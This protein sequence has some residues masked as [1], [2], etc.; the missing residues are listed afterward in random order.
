MH[1]Q[2]T[3]FSGERGLAIGGGLGCLMIVV[4]Y[5]L[6]GGILPEIMHDLQVGEATYSFGADRGSSRRIRDS[7]TGLP[8]LPHLES[9]GSHGLPGAWR[10][11]YYDMKTAVGGGE[12]LVHFGGLMAQH[13]A[14]HFPP[15]GGVKA[16]PKC[17]DGLALTPLDRAGT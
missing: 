1:R 11:R 5:I 2:G 7:D 9:A 16:A 14:K 6:L 3:P 15:A 13:R 10:N 12:K 4:A 8:I 17:A